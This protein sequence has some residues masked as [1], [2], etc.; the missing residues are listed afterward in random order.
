M[1]AASA[2]ADL[3]LA[4]GNVQTPFVS[5]AKLHVPLLNVVSCKKISN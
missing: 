5:V 2:I 3:S 4:V 1:P